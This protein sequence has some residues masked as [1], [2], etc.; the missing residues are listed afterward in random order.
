MSAP[1][2]VE[3]LL[4]HYAPSVTDVAEAV[5]ET[6]LAALQGCQEQADDAAGVV[7]YGYGP[8]YKDLVC[9]LILSKK[10]VKLGFYRG[11]ELA[12]PDGLLEGQGKVH[13]YVAVADRGG[14]EDPRLAEL[15][16]NAA[17]AYRMRAG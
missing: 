16:R 7:G 8:G 3:R 12:D 4:A 10:A 17:A 1:A 2:E 13:R 15:L 5:R 14:A 9:T 6:V 11:A